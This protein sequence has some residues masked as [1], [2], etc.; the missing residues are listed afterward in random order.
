MGGLDRAAGS[1]QCSTSQPEA[2]RLQH[3]RVGHVPHIYYVPEYLGAEEEERLVAT[4]K[5][6][7]QRWTQ[8]RR[9][10]N[11]LCF[12][13]LQLQLTCQ[14]RLQVSGRRLQSYGGQVHEKTGVLLAAAVPRQ[15]PKPTAPY[16]SCGILCKT[17]P[18]LRSI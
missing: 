10:Q 5:A 7:K 11:A 4:V 18:L 1:Q 8:V 16:K 2:T 14:R 9:T 3:H 6:S 17:L 15:R 12:G 13:V